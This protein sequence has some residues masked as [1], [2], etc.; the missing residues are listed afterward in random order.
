MYIY[1]LFG[2]VFSW[3]RKIGLVSGIAK[4]RF[5]QSQKSIFVNSPTIEPTYWSKT[6]YVA[7]L[8]SRYATAV[9]GITVALLI[10]DLT[11]KKYSGSI[12]W[13]F[14]GCYNIKLLYSLDYAVLDSVVGIN[15]ITVF[16]VLKIKYCQALIL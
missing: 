12:L 7:R 8:H 3:C 4:V 9:F 13:S 5:G 11:L 16:I 15:S 6:S 2:V 1:P 14:F 10:P